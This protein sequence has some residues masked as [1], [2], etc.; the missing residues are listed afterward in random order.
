MS[1]DIST[2]VKGRDACQRHKRTKNPESARL[3]KTEVPKSPLSQIQVDFMGPFHSSIPEKFRYVLAIHDVLTRYAMLVLTADC[4]AS[5]AA[6]MRLTRWVTVLDI[7][8]VRVTGD[9]TSQDKYFGS[10][11]KPW[12]WSR[13]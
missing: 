5:T 11:M 1:N 4:T 3:W 13:D 7:P 6:S 2:D 8:E 9:L 10:C 12:G